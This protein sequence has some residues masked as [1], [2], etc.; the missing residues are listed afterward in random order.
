[1]RGDTVKII[2]GCYVKVSA[3]CKLNWLERILKVVLVKNYARNL[4]FISNKTIHTSAGE[5][6]V[7]VLAS[8]AIQAGIWVAV[9]LVILHGT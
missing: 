9:I 1:V 2:Y 7:A 6:V 4:T 5:A 8:A 3:K